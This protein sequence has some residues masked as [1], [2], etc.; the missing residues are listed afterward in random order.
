MMT[1]PRP[2][3]LVADDGDDANGDE[4]GLRIGSVDGVHF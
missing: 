2:T 4:L 3:V 1:A